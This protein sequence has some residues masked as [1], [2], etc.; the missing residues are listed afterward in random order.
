MASIAPYHVGDAK[1]ERSLVAVNGVLARALIDHMGYLCVVFV[2]KFRTLCESKE[3]SVKKQ[4]LSVTEWIML[5]FMN[6]SITILA[7][8]TRPH[9]GGSVKIKDATL[10]RSDTHKADYHIMKTTIN[11][12]SGHGTIS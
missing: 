5:I 2:K 4:T 7:N 10:I 12:N 8:I 1:R 11:P 3:I 9:N 6:V